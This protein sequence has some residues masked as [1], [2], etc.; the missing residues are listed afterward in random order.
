[1]GKIHSVAICKKETFGQWKR[2]ELLCFDGVLLSPIDC[3]SSTTKVAAKKLYI[4]KNF[5][6][7]KGLGRL[8]K[9]SE[10]KVLCAICNET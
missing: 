10:R 8:I 1:M 6:F 3:V 7:S 5:F 9:R 2:G 4:K